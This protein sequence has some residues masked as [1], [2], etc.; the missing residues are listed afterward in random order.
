MGIRD[1]KLIYHLTSIQNFESILQNGLL[2][3]NQLDGFVDIADAEIIEFREEHDITNYVPFHFF[4]KNPFDGRVQIDNPDD[5]FIYIC[6]KR[7]YAKDN[8]FLIIPQHPISMEEFEMY[9]YDDGFELIDWVTMDKRDY[10]DATCKN[11]CMAECVSSLAVSSD[12]FHSIY[13][14][15]TE[16]EERIKELSLAHYEEIPFKINVNSKMFLD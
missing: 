7:S 11:V 3:R 4:S 15:S 6:L 8:D 2:P 16:H 10:G 5:E 14:K 1:Q 12:D 13:V 9:A